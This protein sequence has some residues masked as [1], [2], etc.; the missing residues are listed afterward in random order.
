VLVVQSIG[1]IT[2]TGIPVA[3]V[4]IDDTT[5]ESAPISITVKDGYGNPMPDGTTISASV[6]LDNAPIGFQ[7]G[8]T[9]DISTDFPVVI[10]N[11]R[12]ARFPQHGITDFT[13]RVVD[14]STV[15]LPGV[16]P[17]IRITVASPDLGTYTYSFRAQIQ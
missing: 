16:A 12:Y 3:V 14:G 2:V 5:R 11:A 10:P 8:V 17:L 9:G 6:K 1:P 4:L 13:F 7:V 15:Y